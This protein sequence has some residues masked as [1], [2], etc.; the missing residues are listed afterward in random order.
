MAKPSPQQHEVN[1]LLFAVVG[2][3]VVSAITAVAC[4]TICE[5]VINAFS[6]SHTMALFI[7]DAGIKSDDKNLERQLSSA[8]IALKAVRDIGYALGVGSFMVGIAVALR[9]YRGK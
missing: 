9:V 6:D 2:L 3:V 7:T 1:N 8:T 4:A 5:F